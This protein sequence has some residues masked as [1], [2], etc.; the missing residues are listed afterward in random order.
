MR[1]LKTKIKS[2]AKNVFNLLLQNE[3]HCG[4]R[5]SGIGSHYI[6]RPSVEILM[7]DSPTHGPRL[8][9][10]WLSKTVWII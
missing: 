9:H 5:F 6:D 2:P 10:H 8:K 1:P 3:P 7:P 4:K